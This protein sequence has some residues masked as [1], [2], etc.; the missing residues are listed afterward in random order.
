[1]NIG[2]LVRIVWVDG[3]VVTGSYIGQERGYEVFVDNNDKKFVCHPSH[4]KIF[5]VI[6]ESG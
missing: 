1:M 2:D 5:E 6:G 3:L 4:I